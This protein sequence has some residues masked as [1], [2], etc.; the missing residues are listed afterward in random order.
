MSKYVTTT[1]VTIRNKWDIDILS[2]ACE[3]YTSTP[4]SESV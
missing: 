3:I 1:P 2:H 4:Q